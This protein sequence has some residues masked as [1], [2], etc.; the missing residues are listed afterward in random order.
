[1]ENIKTPKHI[2]KVLEF[3]LTKVQKTI[4]N[5]IKKSIYVNGKDSLLIIHPDG[6]CTL[7]YNTDRKITM[8][9]ENLQYV[10]D[11][12]SRIIIRGDTFFLSSANSMKMYPVNDVIEY[13]DA[14][15]YDLTDFKTE[16]GRFMLSTLL[17]EDA[18]NILEI[19]AAIG[20][21]IPANQYI[22]L[23][24]NAMYSEAMRAIRRD[25]NI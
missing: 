18:M 7:Q 25:F 13:E 5:G 4:E 2:I 20:H 3:M 12:V 9:N 11:S 6:Q 14:E 16:E 21:L 10:S 24:T 22:S 23:R 17:D 8:L 1:M 19:D 15:K